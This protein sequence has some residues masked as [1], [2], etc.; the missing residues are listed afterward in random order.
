MP[1][2]EMTSS[3]VPFT[4]LREQLGFV[5]KLFL[6]Q[7][8]SS[9]SL[10]AQLLI[11]DAVWFCDGLLS[12]MERERLLAAAAGA[13]ANSYAAGIHVQMLMLCG[14]S[15]AV[16]HALAADFRAARLDDQSLALLRFVVKAAAC[17]E[18][19]C[20]GDFDVLAA[21]GWSDA[22]A[23]EA[24][25]VAG[26]ARFLA[27]L[28]GSYAP[29][30]DF[31]FQPPPH[32]RSVAELCGDGVGAPAHRPE[33]MLRSDIE[34]A[35]QQAWDKLAMAPREAPGSSPARLTE[36]N[37]EAWMEAVCAYA[38]GCFSSVVS[39]GLAAA[40]IV[41]P[42][43]TGSRP[44]FR[45]DQPAAEITDPDYALVLAARQGDASAFEKLVHLHGR[46]VFRT[47]AGILGDAEEARDAMQDTFLKAFDRLHSFEGRSK[48]STW[49]V[50]IAVNA[51]LQRLR[52]RRPMDSLDDTSDEPE[53][54]FRP[55]H[56]Q[57]WGDSPEQ[58]YAKLEMRELVQREVRKL[59]VKYRSAIVLRDLEQLST[60]E[61]AA[62]LGLGIPTM[63]SR[64]LR[65][66]LLLREALAPFFTGQAV[67][68]P[69]GSAQ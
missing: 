40:Q 46:R 52:E 22:A 16:A 13:L 38:L 15:E 62:A 32:A 26:L 37:D 41:H 69:A 3:F 10:E 56:V 44:T 59:P 17:G 34:V 29:R 43:A 61:A 64:L 57:A 9:R 27:A 54:A 49:L 45:N 19:L 4:R 8:A 30:P 42:A 25:A 12:R 11:M 31:G 6:A 23:A 53:T 60:E 63:K 28:V 55:R 7:Q 20:Q 68:E 33:L 18:K 47:V 67:A 1:V 66:R 24:L 50:S 58:R 65:G 39:T 36:Q 14:V 5:P 2:V 48:F 35:V 51:A 21:A